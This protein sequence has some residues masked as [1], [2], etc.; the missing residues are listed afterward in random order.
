MTNSLKGPQDHDKSSVSRKMHN[1]EARTWYGYSTSILLFCTVTDANRCCTTEKD[2]AERV[3]IVGGYKRKEEIRKRVL[4]PDPSEENNDKWWCSGRYL[5]KRMYRQQMVEM[6]PMF[7]KTDVCTAWKCN[8][9][10]L[11][12]N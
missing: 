7:D 2:I 1:D 10:R 8:L 4:P 6:L 12:K 9:D 11:V 3:G 5:A